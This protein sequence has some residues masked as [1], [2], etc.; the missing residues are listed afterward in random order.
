MSVTQIDY[1]DC[2]INKLVELNMEYSVDLETSPTISGVQYIN[3]IDG[4]A[5]TIENGTNPEG[6]SITQNS[7]GI[8]NNT[9]NRLSSI[10]SLGEL[11]LDDTELNTLQLTPLQLNINGTTGTANQVLKKSDPGDIIEW[12]NAPFVPTATEALEMGVFPINLTDVPNDSTTIINA[13]QILIT[14]G[15]SGIVN[16][17]TNVNNSLL[18]GDGF[19]EVATTPENIILSNT[20]ITPTT[21]TLTPDNMIF[22][23]TGSNKATYGRTGITLQNGTLPNTL[24]ISQD[25]VLVSGLISSVPKSLELT[26]TQL[27]VNTA[28]GSIGQVFTKDANNNVA[29]ANPAFVPTADQALNMGA[30]GIT[31]STLD[32]AA[33][34]NLDLGTTNAVATTLGRN[35]VGATSNIRG[36]TI[37]IGS[38]GSGNSIVVNG[39]VGIT[40]NTTITGTASVTSTFTTNTIQATTA[41]SA[42]AIYNNLTGAAV[43]ILTGLTSGTVNILTGTKT[44]VTNMLTGSGSNTFTM[45]TGSSG[46]S[47]A[48]N[49]LV[50]TFNTASTQFANAIRGTG[51]TLSVSQP[52][53]PT[54]TSYNATSGT[55]AISTG[56][57]GSILVATGG[58][59][60]TISA[61]GTNLLNIAIPSI[62]VYLITG[63]LRLRN[64][65]VSGD[66]DRVLLNI[67]YGATGTVTS[68]IIQYTFGKV[69]FG[70]TELNGFRTDFPFSIVHSV[71]VLGGSDNFVTLAAENDGN[72]KLILVSV[73][74]TMRIVRIA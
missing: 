10:T 37:N 64:D 72:V 4:G 33:L 14:D 22:A 61:T 68:S 13:N 1:P 20:E 70:G 48:I 3:V 24:Q 67:G 56:S 12:S 40:G 23:I 41:T 38:S 46:L 66:V 71:S 6:V 59:S 32:S 52:I 34:T 62:G 65:D 43:D 63:V 5:I 15:T 58:T 7:I 42:L 50:A 44:G 17:M 45:G 11:N 28:Q 30:F 60:G 19:K 9:T 39:G 35:A 57:I 18:S 73:T 69:Q 29:W 51:T 8:L 49:G 55:G 31:G 27:K 26:Q 16:S 25:S 21:N 47:V 2:K 54:I 74:S 53:V 36:G